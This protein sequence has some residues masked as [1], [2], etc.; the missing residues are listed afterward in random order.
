MLTFWVNTWHTLSQ[1]Y[2]INTVNPILRMQI[3]R[4][5]AVK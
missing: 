3:V 1:A 4:L 2:T 5:K